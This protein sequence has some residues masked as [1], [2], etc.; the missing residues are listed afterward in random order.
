MQDNDQLPFILLF[1]LNRICHF[2]LRCSKVSQSEV[3]ADPSDFCLVGSFMFE[4]QLCANIPLKD[5][6]SVFVRHVAKHRVIKLP[7]CRLAR[8]ILNL[9]EI[10]AHT[11]YHHLI[12]QSECVF[13]L[14]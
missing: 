10:S 1:T 8:N 13:K 11:P 14:T 7:E 6:H 2:C 3:S 9:K 5:G 12:N 4:H